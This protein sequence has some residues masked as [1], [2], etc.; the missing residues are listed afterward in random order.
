MIELL[1]RY[2]IYFNFFSFGT[3]LVTVFSG[4]LAVFT[5]TIKQKSRPTIDLGLMYFWFALFFLGYFVAA[6]VY[7]PLAVYHRYMT[8]GFIFPALIHLVQW[9]LRYPEN[10]H[11]R[12]RRGFLIV[13]YLLAIGMISAFIWKTQTVPIKFH[14]NGHY[15]DFDAETISRYGAYL[16]M[17]YIFLAPVIGA[18]KATIVTEKKDRY[19]IIGLVASL[20]AGAAVPAI[21]NT[22]SRDG[23]VDRGFYLNALVLLSIVAFFSI[24]ILFLNTT[25]D[26]TTFM[27]KI[28]GICMVTFLLLFQGM[29]YVSMED[30]EKEYDQIRLQYLIRAVEGGTIESELGY[31]YVYDT[32]K[33]RGE[34]KYTH[35]NYFNLPEERRIDFSHAEIEYRNTAL[36][37]EIH[38]MDPSQAADGLKRLLEKTPPEFIGYRQSLERFIDSKEFQDNPTIEAV[39]AQIDSLNQLTFVNKN[40][41]SY[42]SDANFRADVTAR[43]ENDGNASFAPFRDA[44][45][46]ELKARSSLQGEALKLRLG[47]YMAPFKPQYSRHY[48]HSRNGFEHLIA[49]TVYSPETQTVYE[50]GFFYRDYRA[51]IHRTAYKQVTILAAVLFMV[52]IVFPLFFRGSLVNPLTEL[53]EG[54]TKVNRGNLDV[55]VPIH[56]QDEIGFLAASFNSMVS[57]IREA[58]DQ[59][60]DYANNLEEKVKERTAELN[61]TLEEVRKLK[62]QQDGDYFLTSLLMKPLNF[63]ANKSERVRSNFLVLQK[64]QFEFRN[65]SADL[66]GDICVTGNL[67]LGTRESYRRYL[68]AMNGDAMGKSMQGAGGALVMGVVMN[69]ILARSASHDRILDLTPEA[70]LTEVYEE[71]N[72]VFK[73]FN[74]SMVISCVVDVIDEETGE[75]FYF[76]AEHPFQI[77]YRNGKASFIEEDLQLRKLGLESEIPFEVK[78]F[79]L[80]PGDAIIAGSDGRDDID[81][82]PDEPVRTINEDEFL[83]LSLVDQARGDLDKLA[84]LIKSKGELTD[85][86]SLLKIEFMP[87]SQRKETEDAF[88][89]EDVVKPVVLIDDHDEYDLDHS[90]LPAGVSSEY[91][92][93]LEEGRRLVR[94]GKS[95]E[96]LAKLEKAYEMRQDDPALNKILAVLTFREKDYEK[97]VEILENYLSH[98]PNIE[99]FWLYLSIAHKRMGN[100][101]RSLESA[102]KVFEINSQRVPNLLQLA[103]LHFRMGHA[104]RAKIFLEQVFQIDPNN[105]QGKTLE[106]KIARLAAESG[107]SN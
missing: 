36:Y 31:L 43:L 7:S 76:N 60:R 37:E 66:G 49:Y 65:K 32:T 21:L 82:T 70:W 48:R 56:V 15:W 51:F 92:E 63:N 52:L 73:A 47:E 95:P 5:L 29:A 106:E 97:A 61:S 10:T 50:G 87:S 12:L 93:L 19:T 85:D 20:V 59:L 62:I 2:D 89:D 46:A 94:A 14:F 107:R 100:L 33:G 27:A 104:G 26:R 102:E 28:V 58:R 6:V 83:V 67:R 39:F 24:T 13:Q 42:I 72:G 80:E 38:K 44:M 81:L 57:S 84:E 55:R 40:R 103:D 74:G 22:L 79:R 16:I 91:S 18:W 4:F 99:D 68:V 9:I 77:L 1:N 3:L 88:H 105:S 23:V 11:P 45:L 101:D 86:L 35:E 78:R 17:A 75:M 25:T 64:K 54:V 69:S 8:L 90:E 30:R 41:I 96:A 71:I 34:L 53:L 98:D